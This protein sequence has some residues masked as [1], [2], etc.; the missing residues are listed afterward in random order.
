M[1]RFGNPKWNVSHEY[2][3]N[4]FKF[5]PYFLP[6][7]TVL[8]KHIS[9]FQILCKI[10][11]KYPE[12]WTTEEGRDPQLEYRLSI[13]HAVKEDSGVYTCSTPA[14]HTHAIEVVVKVYNR[15][16]IYIFYIYNAYN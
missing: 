14:R 8:M 10:F 3:Y 2:R 6:L 12:G 11:R 9:F 5:K 13:L 7:H 1:R 16:K 4:N 15:I